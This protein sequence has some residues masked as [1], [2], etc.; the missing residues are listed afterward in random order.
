MDS[1][2]TNVWHSV[3]GD[4][5]FGADTASDNL[6]KHFEESATSEKMKS[7]RAIAT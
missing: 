6:E 2:L 5:G 4:R 1:K 3:F 7:P